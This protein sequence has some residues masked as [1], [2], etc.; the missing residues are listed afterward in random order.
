MTETDN[1]PRWDMSVIGDGLLA[2]SIWIVIGAV[3]YAMGPSGTESEPFVSES[4]SRHIECFE[5]MD[6]VTQAWRCSTGIELDEARGHA[7][8]GR[9]K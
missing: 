6:D 7:P 1:A 2:L 4:I 3:A 9:A 8:P 5:L